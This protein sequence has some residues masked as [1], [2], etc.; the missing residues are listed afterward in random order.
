MKPAKIFQ[1]YIWIVNTLRQYKK[2]SL[3]QLN[4]LWVKDQVIEGEAL[5]RKSF[6]RHKDAI[7]NMFGIIIECDLEHGYKYYISNPEVINDDTIEGWMLST[8]TVNTILSD[9]ASL[10]NRILLEN[11]PAGEEYLQTIILALKTNR[12]LNI[13]YQRFGCESYEKTVSPYA[14]KLFR[15]RWYI[16]TYTG[17]HMATY[18]LDRMLSVEITDETFEMPANFSPEDY[19]AEYYR[20]T[21]DDTPMAHVV[22]RAYGNLPNYLRTLPL[23]TSQKETEHTDE[24]TDFSY[25]IR[26]SV[27]FILALMSYTDSLEVLEPMELRQKV[28][29]S[30]QASLERYSNKNV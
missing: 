16:L 28:C 2:L 20:I 27:D 15:Q 11:V 26:P 13:T 6:L 8:L 9:S 10:R 4:E 29:N 18:A 24:Y 17:R 30:L 14:L 19:F 25:D 22:I 12:R 1:Q 3:E 7:L 5:N 23:H 21:T